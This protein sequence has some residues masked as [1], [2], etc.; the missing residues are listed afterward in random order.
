MCV[1]NSMDIILHYQLD[2]ASKWRPSDMYLISCMLYGLFV[3]YARLSCNK[4][5]WTLLIIIILCV[6][7]S[8]YNTVVSILLCVYLVVIYLCCSSIFYM[9]FSAVCHCSVSSD[10]FIDSIVRHPNLTELNLGNNRLGEKDFII[11]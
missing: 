11:L 9:L 4:L 1:V 10:E 7:L 6:W 8:W 5:K 3:S 2:G